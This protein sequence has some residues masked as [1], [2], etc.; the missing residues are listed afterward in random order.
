MSERVNA[1]LKE[2]NSPLVRIFLK[3]FSLLL[4]QFAI[5]AAAFPSRSPSGQIVGTS[6][7]IVGKTSF[8]ER[9]R[10]CDVILSRPTFNVFN[11]ESNNW[12]R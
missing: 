1:D 9:Y 8:C 5:A 4:C 12:L 7:Q 6:K 11:I 2:F 10:L 3:Y